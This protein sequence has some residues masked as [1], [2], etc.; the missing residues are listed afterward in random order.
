MKRLN[1]YIGFTVAAAT[2]VVLIAFMGLD[3]VFRVV[4]EI[5]NIEADYTFAKV[6][7]Y[8]GLRTFARM[9]EIMPIVGLIGCLTGLGALANSSEI[10][11]MRSAGVSVLRLVFMALRP[12]LVFML[13]AIF[14]G[15]EIAPKTEQ[16]AISYRAYARHKSAILDV[17]QGLWL[18]D[19]NSFIFASVVQPNG[20]MFGL[21]VFSFD[22][23]QALNGIMRAERA[24]FKGSHWLLE[25]VDNTVFENVNGMPKQISQTRDN[26]FKWD[27]QLKPGLLS[28]AAVAPDDLKATELIDYVSYLKQQNLNSTEYELAFWEKVFFPLVMISLV[29]VGISFVFGPLRQVSMGYRVFWG[30]L[31]GI[32]FKTFQDML[33]PLSMVYGYS[34]MMAMLTPAILCGLLGLVLIARVR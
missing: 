24:T 13:L 31:I 33:G 22:D 1:R 10:I 2:A 32:M 7:A 15:E 3:L 17:N 29:L 34:P 4:E 21:N 25:A 14:I 12:A 26:V 5:D 30:V 18:R 16:M 9:Y 27:S 19:G 23:D 20:V 28:I 11:V 8:E 6:L